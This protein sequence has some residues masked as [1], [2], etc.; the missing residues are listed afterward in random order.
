MKTTTKKYLSNSYHGYSK[1]EGVAIREEHDDGRVVETFHVEEVG[2]KQRS[3]DLWA[4]Q[5]FRE[6]QE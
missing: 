6:I 5:L 1:I 2:S 4:K 3:N